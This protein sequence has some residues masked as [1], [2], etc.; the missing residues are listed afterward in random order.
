[1]VAVES[2]PT[3]REEL[4]HDIDVRALVRPVA[5]TEAPQL[6]PL[7][8]LVFFAES[9]SMQKV[10]LGHEIA[11]IGF[12]SL[13]VTESDQVVPEDVRYTF[14]APSPA[15]Q[16]TVLALSGQD[17]EVSGYSESTG[18]GDHGSG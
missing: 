18:F 11:V 6:V 2:A 1:M 9:V 17:M 5:V 15:A 10:E 14:P 7:Y 16:K 13:V 4:I 12:V 3:H 8:V